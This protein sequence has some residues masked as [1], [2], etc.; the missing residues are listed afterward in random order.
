MMLHTEGSKEPQEMKTFMVTIAGM[1]W[2]RSSQE[3]KS[4]P[5]P[6]R[7]NRLRSPGC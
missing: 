2:T 6:G 5:K 7:F 3:I 4:P 1:A